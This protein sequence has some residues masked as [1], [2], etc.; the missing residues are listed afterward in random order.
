MTRYSLT[1]LT[2]GQMVFALPFKIDTDFTAIRLDSRFILCLEKLLPANIESF[3]EVAHIHQLLLSH[4]VNNLRI[5]HLVCLAAI[6]N[7]CCSSLLCRLD[8]V[9]PDL[10]R[11][12]VHMRTLVMK[13]DGFVGGIWRGMI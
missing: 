8:T 2:R 5:Q 9:E 4:P 1:D 7:G 6:N 11:P 10:H 12:A 13:Q 3:N